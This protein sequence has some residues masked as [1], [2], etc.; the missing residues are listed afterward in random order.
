MVASYRFAANA[1]VAGLS[2]QWPSSLV[3]DTGVLPNFD[4]APNGAR[5]AALVPATRPG[6][7]QTMNHVTVMLNFADEVRRRAAAR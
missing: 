2:R 4:L 3:A 5:I 1:F 6:G 7:E